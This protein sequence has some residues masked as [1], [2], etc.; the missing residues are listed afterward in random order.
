MAKKGTLGISVSKEGNKKQNPEFI[1]AVAK[2]KNIQKQ[3]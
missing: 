2:E 1:A 3:K